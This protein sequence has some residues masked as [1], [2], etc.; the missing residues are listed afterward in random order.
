MLPGILRR[1][2][3]EEE[4]LSDHGFRSVSQIHGKK[5][6]LGSLPVVGRA[7]ID[8]EPGESTLPLFGGNSN[9]RG[10][11]WMPINYSILQALTKFY[12]Y[13]GPNFKLNVPALADSELNLRET[14]NAVGERLINIFRRN[15]NG[16]VPALPEDSPFQNDPYWMNLRL[17]SEYYHGE[18]GLGLGASH[19]TG[20][21]GLVANLIKRHYTLK[22]EES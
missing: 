12:R 3:N 19:Q 21:S 6:E 8:Y 1:L 20:W 11:V 22:G 9:W 14:V 7:L 5:R 18:T 4:F 16:R 15:E 17:F 10:P 13:L 2:L